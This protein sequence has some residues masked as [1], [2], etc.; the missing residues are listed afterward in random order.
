MVKN[1]SKKPESDLT[2]AAKAYANL[3]R[4]AMSTESEARLMIREAASARVTEAHAKLEKAAVYL[5]ESYDEDERIFAEKIL[6]KT[7]RLK[8]ALN[9]MV[10][11]SIKGEK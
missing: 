2:K 11:Q 5:L 7:K 9:K 10:K 3:A 6:R 4:A 8:T 1:K